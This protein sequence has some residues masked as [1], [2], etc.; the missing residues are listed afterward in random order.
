MS[1]L[2]TFASL[3]LALLLGSG[4]AVAQQEP[5]ESANPHSTQNK[6]RPSPGAADKSQTEQGEAANPHST[7]NRERQEGSASRAD[8]ERAEKENPHATASR[9][10]NGKVTAQAV[11]ERLSVGAQDEV[12]MGQLAQQNGGARAQEFGRMLEQD[13]QRGLQQ[14]KDLA[15]QKGVTLV[16]T[17]KDEMAKDEMKESQKAHDKLA[18][19]HGSEFDKEFAD[20]MI[21][22]HEKDIE[23]VKSWRSSLSNDSETTALLDQTL[24][25]LQKHLKAAQE[26]KHP[27]AMGRRPEKP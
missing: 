12:K 20:A 6:D 13:H 23:H 16:D 24:P 18:K 14:V 7:L 27:A 21:K 22:D 9:E 1:A 26:L 4:V 10:K 19:L 25:V 11:L 15:Q 3:S 5:G 8:V 2:R 17:P